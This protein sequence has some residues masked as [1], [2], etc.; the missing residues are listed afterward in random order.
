MNMAP[1]GGGIPDDQSPGAVAEWF[2]KVADHLQPKLSKLHFYLHNNF[3]G[4]KTTVVQVAQANSTSTSP[5]RFGQVLVL[6]G[7]LTVTPDVN[8]KEIGRV[9]GLFVFTSQEELDFSTTLTFVFSDGKYRGSSLQLIGWSPF[10]KQYRE[11]PL[12]GGSGDLRLAQGIGTFQTLARD[13]A[14]ETLQVDF[15]FFH[16]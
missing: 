7:L 2:E 10:E 16:Y 14:S 13:A 11:F 6:D 1:L 5:T 12:V 9:Q 15:I 8:S 4:N 3:T